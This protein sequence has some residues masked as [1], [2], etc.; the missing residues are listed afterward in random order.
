V[1]QREHAPLVT[2]DATLNAA[3]RKAKVKVQRF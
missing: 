3:A 1:Q 2:A